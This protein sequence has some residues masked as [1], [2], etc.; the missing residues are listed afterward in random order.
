MLGADN[1]DV[2]G[3][4]QLAFDPSALPTPVTRMTQGLAA[5]NAMATINGVPAT[6]ATNTLD[7]VLDGL[8]FKLSQVTTTAVDVTINRDTVAMR[9]TVT[10][11]AAAYNDLAKLMREQTL[12]TQG[13]AAGGVLQGD[14]SAKGLASQLR[15]L[16]GSSS[17]AAI[18][19]TRLVDVGLEPQRDGSLKVNDVKLDRA[20]TKLDELSTF[21]SREEDGTASDGFAA[22]FK[23]FGDARLADDGLFDARSKAL[24]ERIERGTERQT[25]LEARLVLT[26]KRLN[27]QYTRLDTNLS[28]LNSLQNYVTQQIA[29]WNRSTR[30]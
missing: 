5:G 27:E 28:N 26:E 7:N 8:S 10:D 18:D 15:S 14:S 2:A 4:S 23:N 19:F 30:R 17:A 24:K 21:F 22:L 29:S 20:L 11:F 6:S 16:V 1:T 12:T 25:R 9:K 13:G 3:L